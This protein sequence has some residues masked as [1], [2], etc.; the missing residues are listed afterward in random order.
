[1]YWEKTGDRR[2]SVVM[3]KVAG[4]REYRREYWRPITSS[5]C[6]IRE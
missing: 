5:H 2:V 6:P 3:A 1:M 4:F